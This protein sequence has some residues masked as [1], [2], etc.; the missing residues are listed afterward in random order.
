MPLLL[1]DP[2]AP[3]GDV[4]GPMLTGPFAPVFDEAVMTDLQVEGKIP[5]DLNGVYLRN[6]PNPRY[7][8]K[9]DYHAFDGDGMI[10]AAE[11]RNGKVTYRNKWI[12]TADWIEDDIR[13]E[14]THWGIMQ[15]LKGRTD[16]VLADTANT[17]IIGHAGKAVASWYLSGVPYL[18]DPIT[19]ETVATAN[20]VSGPGN[21]MSAHSKVDE[22]TGELIFFDYY[23]TAPHMTYSVVDKDGKLLHTTPVEL[24]GDRLPHDMGITEHYSILHDLPV[25]HDAEALRAGRH[26]IRFDASLPARLGVIPRYGKG[27][28]V[29]WFEFSSCFIYHVVNCWEEGDEVVMI[30][31]R[32]MPSLKENG[33]IDEAKTA[34]R[35][36]QLQMDARLWS[37]R[38]NMKTGEAT[39]ECLDPDRNVEFPTYDSARTGRYTKWGY[40]VDHD[41]MVLRWT[42]LRKYNTDTG[43]CVGAWS[44]GQDDC[45][46]SEPW[47]A[48]ADNQQ[49]EDHGYVITFVWNNK[50]HVQQLQVF[51]ALDISKGPV[52]R[53]TLP[54]RVPS[55]FHACWM[56]ASQIENWD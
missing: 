40:L 38:M 49:S 52:A 20:Y 27:N 8:P 10:H 43:E 24:P 28:E 22:V 14:E 45:W 31:C 34:K 12:R 7:E 17:D 32:Y 47:F 3:F 36:A 26:K 50:T 42:G 53:I 23:D 11:F 6:G 35:I 18:I 51:D 9:G 21:G 2:A 39:E 54:R 44:D 25:Y 46:Y 5:A 33:E 13:G 1:K 41:P 19:L 29:R 37:Y 48:P 4:H 55:G 30:A 15:T 56:K 16:K